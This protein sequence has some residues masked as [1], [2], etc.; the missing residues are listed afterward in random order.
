MTILVDYLCSDYVVTS[1][2]Y[3]FYPSKRHGKFRVQ[4]NFA[5]Y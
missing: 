4:E 2:E 1:Y 5:Y 3:V